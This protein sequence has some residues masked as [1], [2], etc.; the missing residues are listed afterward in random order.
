MTTRHTSN[1]RSSP[2]DTSRLSIAAAICLA[3]LL[4]PAAAF[5]CGGLF[6]AQPTPMA[7][8][9]Q[10]VDQSA[11]LIVFQ[12]HGD[13]TITA[14]VQIQY[15]GEPDNFAWVVPVPGVPEIRESNPR[16]FEMLEQDTG[17]DVDLPQPIG[18]QQNQQFFGGG[19]SGDGIVCG[20][21]A[22]DSTS[23]AE[24]TPRPRDTPV[25]FGDRPV[26]V[27][28]NDFTANFEFH[29]VGAEDTSDLV[30][31]LQENGYNVS[32]NMTPVMDVY[33]SKTMRFL[34]LKLR[35][36]RTASDIQPIAMTYNSTEPM[37]PIQLTA[38]AAQ[39]YMGIQVWIMANEPYVPRNYDSVTIPAQHLLYR[40]DG[41]TNYFAWVAREV[42]EA[43]GHRFI[44]EFIG[45]NPLVSLE[46]PS[47]DPERP[48]RFR[49]QLVSRYYTR[50]S[51][52]HMTLDPVFR[53]ARDPLLRVGR[54]IDMTQNM[55]IHTCDASFN[56]TTI[57]GREPSA[58]AYN[59]CG[60][61]ASCV[62]I[63]GEVG[64]ECPEGRVA[65]GITGPAGNREVVC[66][67]R[68][69]PYGI[70]AQAAGVGTQFDP[71]GDFVCGDGTCVVR[72]G[73]PT[74]ECRGDAV[75]TATSTGVE[76]RTV[77]VGVTTYGPG[78]GLEAAGMRTPLRD[79]PSPTSGFVFL[80]WLPAAVGLGAL[81]GVSLRRR[82]ERDG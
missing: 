18:C 72:A 14:H 58:C 37:V 69:N 71:C 59:Y 19:D 45:D 63:D 7:P 56:L 68:D 35:E 70:T 60:P 78:A 82:R 73:F 21:A 24:T 81:F 44:T 76:C 65:Q 11:E 16:L 55:P 13:G 20:G 40:G 53:I 41:T 67:P 34:A 25:P 32:D 38:V 15:V 29:I 17:L 12:V 28:A 54:V 52:E 42:E 80:L 75:A 47:D 48:L 6:C 27:Y 33:N 61:G 31:W 62:E 79:R 2:G 51:P 22:S 26:K 49:E 9:P 30:G 39:P 23:G 4:V 10:P 46:L 57:D 64:C 36:G 50:M 43:G 66:A 8:E 1:R 3:T 77:E 74:C 5:A